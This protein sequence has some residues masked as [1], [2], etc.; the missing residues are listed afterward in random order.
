[1]TSGTCRGGASRRRGFCERAERLVPQ[2]GVLIEVRGRCMG[3][4]PF[5]GQLFDLS[6][7]GCQFLVVAGQVQP[8]RA[9]EGLIL[10][11]GD[12]T[13]DV[14]GAEV[15]WVEALGPASLLVAGVRFHTR[16]DLLLE[17]FRPVLRVAPTPVGPSIEPTR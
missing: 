17:E 7:S 11:H 4:G 16:Q 12:R 13:F 15:T 9:V 14:N 10:R 2:R 1:M 5:E 8:K 6:R 3:L